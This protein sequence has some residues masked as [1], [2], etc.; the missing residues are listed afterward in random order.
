MTNIERAG[1]I[2]NKLIKHANGN[3]IAESSIFDAVLRLAIDNMTSEQIE[4]LEEQ[5]ELIVKN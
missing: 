3:F 1:K 5:V 2:S 4:K